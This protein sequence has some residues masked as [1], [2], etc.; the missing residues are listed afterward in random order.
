MGN[1]LCL[2]QIIFQLTKN[3]LPR[4]T[5][6][7]GN[8]IEPGISLI[9][10]ILSGF[11]KGDSMRCGCPKPCVRRHFDVK[12]WKDFA[13]TNA[14]DMQVLLMKK[15]LSISNERSYKIVTYIIWCQLLFVLNC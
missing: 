8:E 1:V 9:K 11:T 7:R 14:K 15:N 6:G 13:H 2:I 12:R 10:K 4:R 5:D 3:V